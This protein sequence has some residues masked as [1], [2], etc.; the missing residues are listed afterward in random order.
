MIPKNCPHGAGYR[1]GSYDINSEKPTEYWCAKCEEERLRKENSV[2]RAALV[3]LSDKR[4]H[5]FI[6]S[7]PPPTW[8]GELDNIA[9]WDFVQSIL[10]KLERTE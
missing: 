7:I 9:P 1:Y 8:S 4:N 3:L 5:R 10:D 2:M 6:P